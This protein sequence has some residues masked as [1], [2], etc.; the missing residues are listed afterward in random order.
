[1]TDSADETYQDQAQEI[2]EA[3]LALADEDREAAIEIVQTLDLEL[4]QDEREGGTTTV[5]R[6]R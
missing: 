4:F 1:M 2:W 6:T 3:A 5:G